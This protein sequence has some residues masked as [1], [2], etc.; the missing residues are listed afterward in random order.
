MATCSDDA[1]A[2]IFLQ[3][4]DLKSSIIQAFT[5]M[6]NKE[7]ADLCMKDNLSSIRSKG[8]GKDSLKSFSFDKFEQELQEVTPTFFAILKAAGQNQREERNKLRKGRAVQVGILTAAAK[9]IF[10][11]CRDM[12]VVQQITTLMMKKGG[13]KKSGFKRLG[14]TFDCMNYKFAND[15]LDVFSSRFESTIQ[16]WKEEV[17]NPKCKGKGF[18]IGSDNVDWELG[19]RY[20]TSDNQRKSIHKINA[21]AYEN[22]VTNDHLPSDTSQQDIS[23]VP[24]TEFLPGIEHN[25]VLSDHLIILVGNIWAEEIPALL[26]FKNHL[27]AKVPHPYEKEMKQKTKKTQLGCFA[28]DQ[29]KVDDVLKFLS[30]IHQSY[31]PNHSDGEEIDHKPN[32]VIMFADYLGFERQKAGISEVQDARTPSKRLA[33]VISAMSD[34]HAQAE[35]H[36]VCWHYLYDTYTESEIGTLYHAKQATKSKDVT[37]DPHGNFYAAENLLNKFTRAYLVEG[38][39]HHFGM[40]TKNDPPTLN[41]YEGD[42][43]PMEFIVK[44]TMTFLEN[45]VLNPPPCQPGENILKCRFCGKI[46]QKQKRLDVHEKKHLEALSKQTDDG[47]QCKICGK[48]YKKSGSLKSHEAKHEVQH[49]AQQEHDEINQADYVYNYTRRVMALLCIRLNFEDAIK[50]GDGARVF[51]CYRFMYLYCKQAGCPKYAYGLL[52]TLAQAECLLSEADAH[53]LVWNRFVNNQGSD[54]SNIPIDLDIEH[55]NKPLKTDVHTY[56]GDIT[57]KTLHRI[58]R[59]VEESEAIVKNFDKQSKTKK[60]SGRNKAEKFQNDVHSLAEL[61]HEKKVFEKKPGRQHKHIGQ[62][63]AD[64]LASLDVKVLHSWMKNTLKNLSRKGY[65][66]N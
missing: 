22:R 65:Y 29:K 28:Y 30:E 63:S 57:D 24:L 19:R 9:V 33:G 42:I 62:I 48:I 26:W 41:I 45:H 18:V 39:L 16:T 27:P 50:Y 6:V 49:E 58:S 17:E 31:V 47:H 1:I 34:F 13:L 14:K 4:S 23:T 8:M 12:N 7:I 3:T 40:E 36:K 66:K 11:R 59:S 46:F 15:L 53:S 37:K 55:L 5:E 64:P 54:N 44:V 32:K 52:E 21:A 38:A 56:R 61:L 60:A 2:K 51:L 20:I 43:L 25:K 10:I 35:W